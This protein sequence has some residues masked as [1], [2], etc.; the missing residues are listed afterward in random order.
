MSSTK[1]SK[2]LFKAIIKPDLSPLKRRESKHLIYSHTL[3]KRK[4]ELHRSL[5]NLL[6]V[7]R[8]EVENLRLDWR[9]PEATFLFC[10]QTKQKRNIVKMNAFFF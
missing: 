8:P 10:A 9:L 5:S 4:A 3:K 2:F 1:F 6:Y 7:T